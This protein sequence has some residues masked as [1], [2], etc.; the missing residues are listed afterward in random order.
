MNIKKRIRE[1]G[2]EGVIEVELRGKD[3]VE[4]YRNKQWPNFLK[5]RTSIMLFVLSGVGLLWYVPYVWRTGQQTAIKSVFRIDKDI[6]EYWELIEPHLCKD[7][8]DHDLYGESNAR[9]RRERRR[10]RGMFSW[11]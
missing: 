3:K 5:S 11:W 4:V 7:G 8:F 6:A 9:S 2:F 10:R 1:H